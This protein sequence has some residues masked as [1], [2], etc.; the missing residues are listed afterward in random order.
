MYLPH[1]VLP[2]SLGSL[3]RPRSALR[4]AVEY[5][6]RQRAWNGRRSWNHRSHYRGDIVVHLDHF[7][8][9]YHGGMFKLYFSPPS[10]KPR[11][12]LALRLISIHV[13]D[14]FI[15]AS[16][17]Q[18]GLSAFLHAL[19]LHWVEANSKHYE[20]GGYV[21]PLPLARALLG[22]EVDH[23]LMLLVTWPFIAIRAAQLRAPRR[24]RMRGCASKLP[25]LRAT[26]SAKRY[27]ERGV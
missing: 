16:S 7:H 27:D 6:S 26:V 22:S 8:S 4:G 21:R 10:L 13:A 24:E 14:C 3:P 23:T 12:V 20:A 19:R 1:R 17:C 25:G 9:L 15:C 18:Q 5:D 2:P 11:L